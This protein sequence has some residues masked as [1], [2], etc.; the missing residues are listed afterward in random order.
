M[1]AAPRFSRSPQSWRVFRPLARGGA[2]S[3]PASECRLWADLGPDAAGPPAA[4]PLLGD[5]GCHPRHALGRNAHVPDAL[6]LDD[7]TQARCCGLSMTGKWQAC[8]GRLCQLVA[9][10]SV[11]SE[12]FGCSV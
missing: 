3:D 11:L 7:I 1:W 4:L 10:S 5:C 6:I 12:L 8:L 9:R 2:M